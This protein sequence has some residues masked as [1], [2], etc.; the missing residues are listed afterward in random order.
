MTAEQR[1]TPPFASGASL[2]KWLAERGVVW[3]QAEAS[4]VADG[5]HA[6]GSCPRSCDWCRKRLAGAA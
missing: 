6:A 4:R 1:N 5:W 3:S 2:R